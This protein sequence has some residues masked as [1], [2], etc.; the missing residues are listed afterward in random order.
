MAS[1]PP[2]DPVDPSEGQVTPLREILSKRDTFSTKTANLMR[3]LPFFLFH[4][5]HSAP[6]IAGLQAKHLYAIIKKPLIF[7][8]AARPPATANEMILRK[9]L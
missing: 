4:A 1:E 9:D 5:S 2:S 6:D 7:V 3:D 8:R